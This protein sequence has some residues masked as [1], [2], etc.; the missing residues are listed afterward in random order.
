MH[1]LRLLHGNLSPK[2][3][4]FKHNFVLE[5]LTD[6]NESMEEALKIASD[7]RIVD[8]SGSFFIDDLLSNQ[9]VNG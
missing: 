2:N 8:F 5:S 6:D 3:V 7:V 1:G 9:T 4:F